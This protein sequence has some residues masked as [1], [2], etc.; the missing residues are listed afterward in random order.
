MPPCAVMS[1]LYPHLF[2]AN[3]LIHTD[4]ITNTS[5]KNY[6][7]FSLLCTVPV[8]LPGHGIPD[9]TGT[10]TNRCLHAFLFVRLDASGLHTFCLAFSTPSKRGCLPLA[11]MELRPSVLLSLAIQKLSSLQDVSHTAQSSP[12]ILSFPCSAV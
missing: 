9:V 3:N 8:I 2:S 7:E 11:T 10:S 4:Y 6:R 12:A 5:Q 1:L